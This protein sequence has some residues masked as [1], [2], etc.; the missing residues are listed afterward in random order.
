[1]KIIKEQVI[2]NLSEARILVKDREETPKEKELRLN[3]LAN[4]IKSS[5]Y[6]ISKL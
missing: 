3:K 2:N 6:L 5:L 1:M 4:L